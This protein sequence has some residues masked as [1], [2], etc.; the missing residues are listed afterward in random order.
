MIG[1]HKGTLSAVA[2]V[3]LLGLA[4]IAGVL[5]F[6]ENP[7]QVYACSCYKPGA[8]FE[9]MEESSAVFA[10]R[11]VSVHPSLPSM[12]RTT[13]GFEVSAVWKG[14]LH[15]YMY[16]TTSISEPSCGFPFIG[17]EEYIVYG[18]DSLNEEGA[19]SV[20]LCSRTAPLSEA[21]VD[22]DAFGPGNP[23][24]RGTGGPAPEPPQVTAGDVELPNTG[25][26]RPPAWTLA[27]AAGIIAVATVLGFALMVRGRRGADSIS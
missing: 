17:G 26:Y 9:E 5:W 18:D 25:G 19:Y 8:P 16:I 1:K 14:N 6:L 24:L 15:E 27:L 4:L 11:V 7:E 20:S 10:G 2:S 22:I 13:V 3:G 21:R 12:Y 23:P